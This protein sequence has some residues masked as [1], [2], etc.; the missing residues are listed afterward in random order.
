MPEVKPTLSERELIKIEFYK[1]YDPMVGIRIAATLSCFFGL[2][3]IMVI[4]KSRWFFLK[5]TEMKYNWIKICNL[6]LIDKWFYL[7][8]WYTALK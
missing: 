5:N 3:V 1:T 7:R 8:A 4:Y 2:I 6:I